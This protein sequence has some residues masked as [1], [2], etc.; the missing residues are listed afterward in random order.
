M[1][2]LWLLAAVFLA[3]CSTHPIANIQDYFRPGKMYPNEVEPYGG[4]CIQQGA[5]LVPGPVAPPPNLPAVV[6]P[7]VPLPG[8][9]G[10]AAPP[11]AFP[12]PPLPR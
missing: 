2:H 4:V 3:G 10:A 11:P 9:T 8:T 7:P 5:V 1:R 12:L 6:P